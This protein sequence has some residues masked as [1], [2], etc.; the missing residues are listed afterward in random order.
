MLNNKIAR[1]ESRIAYLESQLNKT[2]GV[3]VDEALYYGFY[4]PVKKK[5]SINGVDI[6][7][8]GYSTQPNIMDVVVSSDR[9]NIQEHYLSF[10]LDMDR[11]IVSIIGGRTKKELE[12][13]RRRPSK[14]VRLDD[15]KSALKY[16][17]EHLMFSRLP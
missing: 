14:K 4:L 16:I 12:Y 11:D 17:V 1:L 9:L 3:K 7:Q 6:E 2:A 13:A 15:I 5:L 8:T 10:E